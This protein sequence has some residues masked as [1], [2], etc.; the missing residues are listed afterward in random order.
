MPINQETQ[1]VAVPTNC[2]PAASVRNQRPSMGCQSQK[3]SL[4]PRA[5]SPCIRDQA[6]VRSRLNVDGSH[7][8]EKFIVL[9]FRNAAS[10]K[11]GATVPESKPAARDQPPVRA[12]CG[13]VFVTATL[14]TGCWTER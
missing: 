9:V 10:S 14:K 2:R 8:T 6:L 12:R 5:R 1:P 3:S 11:G 13:T 4:L 7:D